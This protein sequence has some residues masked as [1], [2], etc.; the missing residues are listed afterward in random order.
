MPSRLIHYICIIEDKRQLI[1]GGVDG[2]FQYQIMLSNSYDPFQQLFLDP[3][4]EFLDIKLKN[5]GVLQNSSSWIKGLKICN[6]HQMISSWSHDSLNF[7]YFN[8]NLIY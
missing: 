7:N 3:E 5:M 6:D 1:T 8:G 4:S 2:C